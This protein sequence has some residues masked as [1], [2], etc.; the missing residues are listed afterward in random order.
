MAKILIIDDDVDLVHLL[1][2]LLKSWQYEVAS[3]NDP[4]GGL[5]EARSFQPDLIL[6]DYHMPGS[7]GAHLFETFRR[8]QATAGTP[9]VFMSAVASP[10]L[11][12]SEVADPGN[13][14]FIPKPVQTAELRRVIQEMLPQPH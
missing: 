4:S 14:R 1:T 3:A 7:T 5:Q 13:A 6:L 10:D 12:F 2:T 9:I 11:V 8:N